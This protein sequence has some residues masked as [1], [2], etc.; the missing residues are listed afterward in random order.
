MN[1]SIS[2]TDLKNLIDSGRSPMLIEALPKQYYEEEHLPG[3]INIPH[4][5]IVAQAAQRIPDKNNEVVVYCASRECQNSHIAAEALR[6][7]GYTRVYEYTEGKK[8][9]KQAGLPF[10]KNGVTV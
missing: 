4:D 2:G 9:W 10:E 7:M 8:G 3:A 5:Q 6:Q 1:Q